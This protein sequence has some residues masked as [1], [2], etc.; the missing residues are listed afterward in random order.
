MSSC[1]PEWCV[2]ARSHP[3][4]RTTVRLIA[5]DRAGNRSVITRTIAVDGTPPRLHFDRVPALV[6]HRAPDAARLARRRLAGDRR[7]KL[8]GVSV[9]LRGPDGKALLGEGAVKGRFSL[10]LQNVGAG[11]PPAR[12]HRDRLGRQHSHGR[13]RPF[14]GRLDREAALLDRA[15]HRRARRRRRAARAPAQGLRRLQGPVHALL[16]RAHRGRRAQFQAKHDLPVTGIATPEL[17]QLSA[18]RSSCTSS[19]SV[20]S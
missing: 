5:S 1:S 3:E 9:A 4:G 14:T 7:A 17:L 20:S 2:R 19:G 15:R 8:D 11:R 12:D 13:G 10:P 16:Q 6:W 18:E